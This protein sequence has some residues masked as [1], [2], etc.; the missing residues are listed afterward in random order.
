MVHLSKNVQYGIAG[1]LAVY[2]VFFTRP[3]PAAVVSMLSNPLAQLAVLG[4]IVYVGAT[5]S[6]LVALVAA[7]AVVLSIPGREF[8]KNKDDAEKKS[9]K[10]G[11][12]TKDS[13]KSVLDMPAVGKA[14]EAV[15]KKVEDK[16]S[17]GEP[18]PAADMI[19]SKPD[20]TKGSEGFT[21]GGAPF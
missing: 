16:R 4:A 2:I 3:A 17:K 8:M 14:L 5:I 10:E 11:M 6:L 7:V 15:D 1:A 21:S 12:D 13:L 9:K 18:T 20:S 19:E